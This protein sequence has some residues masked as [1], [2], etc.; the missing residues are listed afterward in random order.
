MI[1]SDFSVNYKQVPFFSEQSALS[2]LEAGKLARFI[3][4]TLVGPLA[5]AVPLV[6]CPAVWLAYHLFG[7][8]VHRRVATSSTVKCSAMVC[9]LASTQTPT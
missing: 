8:P 2:P 7:T 1:V 6:P 4:G 9:T 5:Q 3:R